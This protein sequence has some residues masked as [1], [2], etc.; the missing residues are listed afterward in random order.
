MLS[1][2]TLSADVVYVDEVTCCGFAGDKGFNRPELNAHALQHLKPGL[3]DS[4]RAGYSTSRTCEIGLTRATETVYRSY[5]YL[6][7]RATRS[8]VRQLTRALAFGIYDHNLVCA[9]ETLPMAETPGSGRGVLR[10][11]LWKIR[12]RAGTNV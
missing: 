8:G 6:I 4:C 10:E 11:R 2:R 5:L 3:P 9:R 1:T 12:A 7:E